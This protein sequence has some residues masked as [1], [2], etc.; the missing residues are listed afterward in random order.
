[1]L[2]GI[3][4]SFCVCYRLMVYFMGGQLVFDWDRPENFLIT[5]GGLVGNEVTN[6]TSCAKVEYHMCKCNAP[7][8]DL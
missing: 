6:A 4:N 8:P 2:N 1:M 7:S 5:C 3:V